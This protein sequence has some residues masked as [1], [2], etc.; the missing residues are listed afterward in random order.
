MKSSPVG[1]GERPSPRTSWSAQRKP[2]ANQNTSSAASHDG[3]LEHAKA[4][5]RARV[6]LRARVG[7][8]IVEAAELG[9]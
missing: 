5:P 9:R 8:G 6:L 4:R 7:V 2:P 3:R 1:T